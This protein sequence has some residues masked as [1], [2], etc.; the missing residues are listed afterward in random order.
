[1]NMNAIHARGIQKSFVKN[2]TEWLDRL[3]RKTDDEILR[4]NK[5]IA[6]YSANYGK[7]YADALKQL[8]LE[9]EINRPEKATPKPKVT[10]LSEPDP[11]HWEFVNTGRG[12]QERFW[13]TAP[14]LN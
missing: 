8:K 14:R 2:K 12:G 13:V 4:Q 10:K 9:I 5:D 3:R 11:G 1:M 7:T 6:F